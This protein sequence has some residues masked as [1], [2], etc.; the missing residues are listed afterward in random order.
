M[1]SLTKSLWACLTR[2][3]GPCTLYVCIC[4]AC[5][6]SLRDEAFLDAE[7]KAQE[8]WYLPVSVDPW[9]GGPFS[10]VFTPQS[11]AGASFILQRFVEAG[12][13]PVGGPAAVHDSSFDDPNMVLVQL[14]SRDRELHAWLG[15][16]YVTSQAIVGGESRGCVE[17]TGLALDQGSPAARAGLQVGDK[18]LSV[19]GARWDLIEREDDLGQLLLTLLPGDEVEVSV[20]RG[21]EEQKISVKLGQ[22]EF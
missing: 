14:L 6:H 17:I 8:Y 20:L 16:N 19:E 12:W 1:K 10:Y 4:T 11:T 2:G 18:G 21:S 9:T 3:L 15:L 13:R 22:K 5:E 7:G